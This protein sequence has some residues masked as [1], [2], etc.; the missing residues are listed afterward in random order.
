MTTPKERL[1][2]LVKATERIVKTVQ[3][4]RP[5]PGSGSKTQ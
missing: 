1:E 4:E 5:Q 3:P 2:K